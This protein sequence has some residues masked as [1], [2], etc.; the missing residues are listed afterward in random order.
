[1]NAGITAK[2]KDTSYNLII[3]LSN[4]FDLLPIEDNAWK[5]GIIRMEKQWIDLDF[6]QSF[7]CKY[8]ENQKKKIKL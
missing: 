7:N 2:K 3:I 8:F 4:I 6:R 5:S 1:M